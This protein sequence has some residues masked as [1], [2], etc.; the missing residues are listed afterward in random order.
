MCFIIVDNPTE[1]NPADIIQ[2]IG[3][4]FSEQKVLSISDFTDSPN[5]VEDEYPLMIISK[6]IKNPKQ[7]RLFGIPVDELHIGLDSADK[8]LAVFVRL[9]NKDL[10]KKM[11]KAIGDEY[12]A[13]A[14]TPGDVEVPPSTYLWDYKEKCVSLKLYTNLRMFIT[15][16][17]PNDG[18]VIFSNCE[19]SSYMDIASQTAEADEPG[20]KNPE[21]QKQKEEFLQLAYT[22][23]PKG[24]SYQDELYGMT[25][26]FLNLY[27]TL[28]KH[29]YLDE[30]W[31]QLLNVLQQRFECWDIGFTDPI[32]RDYRTAIVLKTP[33]PHGIVVNVSKLIPYYCFYTELAPGSKPG[34]RLGDFIF[35]NFSPSDQEI[36]DWVSEQIQLHFQGYKEFP[37]ALPLVRFKDVEFEDRGVLLSMDEQYPSYFESMTLFNAFFSSNMFY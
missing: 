14:I 2:C 32:K 12:V 36:V 25:P 27:E 1:L 4:S 26:Q 18:L 17:L 30:K 7:F 19:P 37:A 28:R 3:L 11:E 10:V 21:I 5:T 9:E 23:Y 29:D 20:F 33:K 24:I 16:I 13:S 34:R 15:K 31:H 8:I 6:T 35:K 22:F